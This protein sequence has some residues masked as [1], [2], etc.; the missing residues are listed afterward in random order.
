MT[1]KINVV[2]FGTR[3]NIPC[4]THPVR[5]FESLLLKFLWATFIRTQSW[6]MNTL[7]VYKAACS[8]FQQGGQ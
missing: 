6:V 2:S 1:L 7:L 4:W 5:G 8:S 3:A